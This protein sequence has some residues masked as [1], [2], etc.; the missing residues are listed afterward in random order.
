MRFETHALLSALRTAPIAFDAD[1]SDVTIG[2][3]AWT[4]AHGDEGLEVTLQLAGAACYGPTDI[5]LRF[6]ARD[7]A[8]RRTK[9]GEL[10]ARNSGTSAKNAAYHKLWPV[11]PTRGAVAED[12]ALRETL[13][14]LARS[15]AA[16]TE[17]FV[18]EV[19]RG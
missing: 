2:A 7:A 17:C 16:F 4:G 10:V 19:L 14:A 1:K 5:V 13:D 12:A 9:V 8:A 18:R 3:L 11:H 15:R 6:W